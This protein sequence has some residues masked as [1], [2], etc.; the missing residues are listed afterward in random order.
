MKSDVKNRSWANELFSA[1]FHCPKTDLAQM[2]FFHRE[3]NVG[4]SIL[5]QRFFFHQNS[6]LKPKS[7]SISWSRSGI[8]HQGQRIFLLR[9]EIQRWAKVFVYQKCNVRKPTSNFFLFFHQE[10]T[11]G[12]LT[13]GQ[14]AFFYRN[15]TSENQCWANVFLSTEIQ[16]PKK[17]LGQS[18]F[19]IGN[20]T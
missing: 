18:I 14:H 11:V 17:M 3:S 8:R 2:Y 1:E 19:S 4:K 7:S 13:S 16:P 20:L 5:G 6:K 9:K 10:S 12:K 15:M